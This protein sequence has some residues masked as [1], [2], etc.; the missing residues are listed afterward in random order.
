M[1]WTWKMKAAGTLK[2]QLEGSS[3]TISI[4]GISGNIIQKTPEQAAALVNQILDIGG[5]VIVPNTKMSYSLG[6]EVY[7]NE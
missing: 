1:A 5:K 2:G 4:A 3:D 7:D 6:N